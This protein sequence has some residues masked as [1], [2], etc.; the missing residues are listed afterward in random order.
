[1]QGHSTILVPRSAGGTID[2]AVGTVG[3]TPLRVDGED[4]LSPGRKSG[5][6]GSP[7]H[8]AAATGRADVVQQLLLAGVSPLA[9]SPGSS[10]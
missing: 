3:D 8:M 10:Q 7:L 4:V 9:W 5:W 6:G 2:L 1:M